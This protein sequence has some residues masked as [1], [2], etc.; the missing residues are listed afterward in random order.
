M[1]SLDPR[2]LGVVATLG[3]VFCG[4]GAASCGFGTPSAPSDVPDS[5]DAETEAEPKPVVARS[6][7]EQLVAS[8]HR[9]C[10]LRGGEA[11]CFRHDNSRP[12]HRELE[13]AGPLRRIALLGGGKLCGTDVE[14][15]VT[16]GT[17]RLPLEDPDARLVASERTVCVW[18]E[19]AIRCH[20]GPRTFSKLGPQVVELTLPEGA[21]AV[22]SV[23][24]HDYMSGSTRL[25][26]VDASGA[27]FE[28]SGLG[29]E[30]GDPPSGPERRDGLVPM[31]TAVPGPSGFAGLTLDG[32]LLV[33]GNLLDRPVKARKLCGVTGARDLQIGQRRA[34]AL[35]DGGVICAQLWNFDDDQWRAG[36][37]HEPCIGPQGPLARPDLVAMAFSAYGPGCVATRD[38]VMCVGH[39]QNAPWSAQAPRV[40]EGALAIASGEEFVCGRLSDGRVMCAGPSFGALG[41][42]QELVAARGATAIHAGDHVLCAELPGTS[43][44]GTLRCF[45]RATT[46]DQAEGAQWLTIRPRKLRH[47]P[48]HVSVDDRA[49][50]WLHQDRIYRLGLRLPDQDDTAPWLL[51][52]PKRGTRLALVADGVDRA[53]P[54]VGIRAAS[55]AYH[56]T[57]D[58]LL[59]EIKR[60]GLGLAELA[61]GVMTAGLTLPLME[62][63]N[64]IKRRELITVPDAVELAAG[65]VHLCFRNRDGGVRCFGHD[66]SGQVRAHPDGFHVPAKRAITR[67]LPAPALQITAGTFHTCARLKG[68]DVHCWGRWG[69]RLLRAASTY[70]PW[71]VVPQP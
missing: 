68:G 70:P 59:V 48:E 40:L 66:R 51:Q 35:T 14:G 41:Q 11:H 65:A 25:M 1:T 45:A 36:A 23:A 46:D 7:I 33:H 3:A 56:L 44:A 32:E 63:N 67:E 58:G 50:R 57:E 69:R 8:H 37:I 16:C 19:R 38:A 34:C 26:A 22:T 52:R 21:A 27:V 28:W 61:F 17:E 15:G 10:M 2:V 5:R 18:R 24:T 62:M 60:E 12:M 43:S 53:E 4:F 30:D 13:H 29:A 20:V 55:G 6:P 31:A 9:F 54:A 39:Q 42:A 64:P 47:R 71:P 49:V